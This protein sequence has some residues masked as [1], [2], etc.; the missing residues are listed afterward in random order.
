M[1]GAVDDY[2]ARLPQEQREALER[3][4]QDIRSV[5]PEVEEVL[6]SGVPAFRYNG[7]P[8]VSIGAAKRHLSLFIMYGA[9]LETYKD[10]LSAFD[11]SSTVVRFMPDKPLPARL[12][13]KLVKARMAEIEGFSQKGRSLPAS[14]HS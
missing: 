9:V 14:S 10:E 12:V 3:L 8:L 7:K 11:T 6:R 2:L 1:G 4:R 5:V 13:K